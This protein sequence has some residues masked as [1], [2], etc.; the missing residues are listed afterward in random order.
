[1]FIGHARQVV[2]VDHKIITLQGL[3]QNIMGTYG[4]P[5]LGVKSSY[6]KEILVHEFGE[7]IGFHAPPR[8]NQSEVVYDTS[9]SSSFVEA[10]ISLLG[11]DNDQ[12]IQNVARMLR[13][14]ITKVRILPW[15]HR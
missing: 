6:I 5:N 7:G 1:M 14:D 4:L 3:L 10:V 15:P 12:L 9:G 2:F 13:E 8:K 11:I